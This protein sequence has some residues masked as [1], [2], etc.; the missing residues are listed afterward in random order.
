MRA[1]S[2]LAGWKGYAAAALAGGLALGSAA[3]TAQGWRK[4]AEISRQAAA[5]ALER[6]GHAQATVAAIEAARVEENRRTAAVERERD[7]AQKRAAVA[8]ADAAGA[9]SELGRLRARADAL[10]R[11]AADSD[12][13]TAAGGPA[14]A[15]AVDLLSY[16]L[17][18]VSN[19]A[20]E[21]AGVADRARNAGLTCERAY[22]AS[23]SP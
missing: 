6:D 1:V 14:G 13:S 5:F 21:L 15:D 3:W 19:R 23:R 20:A 17:G 8:T 11:A 18:R 12:P 9:R 22:D 4:D 2:A 16:M 10:A 7:D